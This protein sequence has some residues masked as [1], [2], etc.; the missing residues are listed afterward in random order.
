MKNSSLWKLS[1]FL[2]SY[3][4]IIFLTF[5]LFFYRS[6][7]NNLGEIAGQMIKSEP[8]LVSF[9][10][11][12]YGRFRIYGYTSPQALVSLET[13]LAHDETWANKDGYF[14]FANRVSP[15]IASDICLISQ[16]Q[17]GRLTSPVCLPPFPNDYNIEIGPIIM[18]PTLSLNKTDYWVGDQIILSGQTVPNSNISLSMFTDQKKSFSSLNPIKSTYAFTLPEIDSKADKKGNFS[19]ALP[20]SQAEKYRFFAQTNYNQKKSPQSLKL[21]IKVLPWWMIIVKFFWW[22]VQ[23]IKPH[24]L[25]I[26]IL[27]ELIFLIY[28]LLKHYF[29]PK[30]IILY[31]KKEIISLSPT[32]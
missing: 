1:L 19:L 17:F 8:V 31:H 2:N 18:P 32:R 21:T 7:K 11:G 23:I 10:F 6:S 13:G 12:G 28:Y 4:L 29:S 14:E 9:F 30:A 16:D 26:T 15:I 24:L 5:G 27:T 3:L 22:L 20:S 25:E